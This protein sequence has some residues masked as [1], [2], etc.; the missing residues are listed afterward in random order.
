MI[1]VQHIETRWTKRSRGMPGAASRN[2]VPRVMPLP[3]GPE[4]AAEI[5]LHR[6]MA[7]EDDDFHLRQVTGLIEPGRDFTKYWT[8]QLVPAGLAIIV[9]FGYVGQAHG[10]PPRRE[11]RH[12]VFRLEPGEI[13][14]LHVNG[15]FSYTSGQYYKQHFVNVANVE[16]A[17][18]DI[19]TAAAANHFT[20]MTVNL[21]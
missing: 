21:F 5:F 11:N 12:P 1:I 3:P 8:L 16:A 13:G 14:T 17:S 2:A 4:A 20:D 15:R 19:F 7:D 18:R 10:L 6:V 9:E